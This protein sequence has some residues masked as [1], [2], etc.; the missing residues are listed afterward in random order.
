M[1]IGVRR[2]KKKQLQKPEV[3]REIPKKTSTTEKVIHCIYCGEENLP[4]A[5]YCRKCGKKQ[6]AV[7]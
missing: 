6:E 5:I 1:Y 7:K 2:S 4:Q 3:I